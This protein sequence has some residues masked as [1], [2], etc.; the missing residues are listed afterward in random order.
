M[1]PKKIVLNVS[2]DSTSWQ[3]TL[4]KSLPFLLSHLAPHSHRYASEDRKMCPLSL[5][6]KMRS[7][8]LL[9][10]KLPRNATTPT[11]FCQVIVKVTSYGRYI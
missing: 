9:V 1:V 5:S 7:D 6:E 8:V 10:T 4:A 2:S 3:S 11:Q